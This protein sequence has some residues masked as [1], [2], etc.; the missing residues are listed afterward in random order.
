MRFAR[1]LERTLAIAVLGP[2]LSLAPGIEASH[3]LHAVPV[4]AA[5]A[6][7]LLGLTPRERADVLKGGIILRELPNPGRQ[8]KTFEALGVLPGGLDEAYAVITDY[9]RYPEFMPRV[10]RVAVRDVDRTTSIVEIR[11]ALPLGQSKQ[12][13]LEYRA[14]RSG[15][16]FE[17]TWEKLPWPGLPPAQTVKDT[18]GR[19]LVRR[20]EA[21]G[22][23]AAYR[24]YSDPGPVPLGLTGI[25]QSL[26]KRSLADVIE[27]TRR[28]IRELNLP[29]KR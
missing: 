5:A 6:D 19:W 1:A 11:L 18:S 7:P 2:A 24:V 27:R 14:S 4:Q 9:R 15:E 21:G 17:V 13:R 8:G 20:S 26:G 10:E 16:G 29:G 22:V 25:A 12:Y 28:R 23:L 3:G